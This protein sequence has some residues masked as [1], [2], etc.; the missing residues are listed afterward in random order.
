MNK[1]NTLAVAI[2]I[3]LAAALM[4]ISALQQ[5]VQAQGPPPKA[6]AILAAEPKDRASVANSQAH[7][8]PPPCPTRGC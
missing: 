5:A 3:V 7:G 1:T 2:F 4:A 6:Q 8:G